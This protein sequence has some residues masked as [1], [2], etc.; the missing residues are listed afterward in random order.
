MQSENRVVYSLGF[1]DL[2]SYTLAFIFVVGNIVL[3]QLCHL[4]P[5]GG[6][7]FLPIYF[8]TLV[9][10]YRY[11]WR[12]GLLTAL[13]SPLVNHLLFGMPALGVLPLV[14]AK[15]VILALVA[16]FA[17]QRLG[18]L[19]LVGVLAVV[20]IFYQLL[21]AAVEWMALGDLWIALE[22]LR[23]GVAGVVIQIFGGAAVIHYL[24][25]IR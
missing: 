7:I 20:V 3:P 25:R 17:A 21:G 16:G 10:A 18:R 8:F 23:L 13:L 15:S 4:V 5:R 19:P 1:S 11:G 6:L 2:R 9:G 14:L 24:R 12:V 22:T